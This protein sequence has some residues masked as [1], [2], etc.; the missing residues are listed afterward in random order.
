M[1]V[2]CSQNEINL[3][4]TSSAKETFYKLKYNTLVTQ[5]SRSIAI[6][7]LILFQK[8]WVKWREEWILEISQDVCNGDHWY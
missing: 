2:Q 7:S 8:F 5:L 6:A 4:S 3:I 1:T